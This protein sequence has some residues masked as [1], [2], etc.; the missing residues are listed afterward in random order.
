ML[1]EIRKEYDLSILMT[2][3][4]FSSLSR[5]ADQ[6]VLIDHGIKK[7]GEPNEVLSSQEFRTA[8]RM[9]GGSEV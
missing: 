8:F 7:Q 9:K 6:V 1:D 5:Y 3:H 2:T 4:D